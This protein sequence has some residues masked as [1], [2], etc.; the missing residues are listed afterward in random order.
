M[1]LLRCFFVVDTGS[2]MGR[3]CIPWP[4]CTEKCGTGMSALEQIIDVACQIRHHRLGLVAIGR[5]PVVGLGDGGCK[6]IEV[7][8]ARQGTPISRSS[9]KTLP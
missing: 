7:M 1:R 5:D 6:L 8:G 9:K 3:P 4:C 2:P